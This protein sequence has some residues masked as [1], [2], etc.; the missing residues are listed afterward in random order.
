MVTV[1][2]EDSRCTV[3]IG[4]RDGRGIV[5]VVSLVTLSLYSSFGKSGG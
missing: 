5:V 2:V 3:G 4:V 1:T